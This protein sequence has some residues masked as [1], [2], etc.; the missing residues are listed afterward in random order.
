MSTI[1]F[2]GLGVM[3]ERMARNLIKAG[4]TVTVYNRTASKAEAL[5][6][7]GAQMATTP[8]EA[9]RD[10][11]VIISIVAN[12]AA[13]QSMWLGEEG[14][15]AGAT[16]G[17]IALEC[18]TL[19]PTWIAE[20]AHLTTA[21]GLTF[22]DAPVMGSTDAAAG[23]MLK[24]LMGGSAETI[25]QLRPLLLSI[26]NEIFHCGA[27]GSGAA[28]KLV[29][30]TMLAIQMAALGEVVGLAERAGLNT[31]LATRVLSTGGTASPVI[32]RSAASVVARDYSNPA[33]QLQHMRKDV[34][35][36]LQMAQTVGAALPIAT[37]TRELYQLAGT[38]G[39]DTLGMAAVGE[40]V[41]EPKKEI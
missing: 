1:A 31:A 34:T 40:V 41:R 19:S 35:Y 23:A 8:R 5:V 26:G 15:I 36:A 18:S 28:M 29:Y 12:D 33:F 10:A 4:H 9:A 14:V 30:N 17:A 25:E 22:V 32:Q 16:K 6:A 39:Y 3:G 20:L 38:N 37:V 27:T 7:E 11:E 2:L 24:F 21:S 13:S